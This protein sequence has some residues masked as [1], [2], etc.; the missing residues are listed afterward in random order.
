MS[1]IAGPVESCS[2]AGRTFPVAQD[3]DPSR[4]LGGFKSTIE[5]NGDGTERVI[6]ER[7]PWKISGLGIQIDDDAEDQEFIQDVIDDGK[8]VD[9]S[10]TYADGNVYYAQGIVTEDTEKSA[11]NAIMDI[12]LSGGGKMKKQ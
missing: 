3:S 10:I 8:P 4:D 11:K 12:T 2:I 6:Q 7:K 9:I 1:V 5:M